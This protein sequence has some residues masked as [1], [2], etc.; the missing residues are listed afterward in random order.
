[1]F[2]YLEKALSQFYYQ[3]CH[4]ILSLILQ[5]STSF[6]FILHAILIFL[7]PCNSIYFVL[8]FGDIVSQ[9]DFQVSTAQ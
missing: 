3:L 1:M 8:S 4:L 7:F 9:C 5:S 6:V 2:C